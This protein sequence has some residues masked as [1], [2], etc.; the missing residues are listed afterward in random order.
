LFLLPQ[1]TVPPQLRSVTCAAVTAP[2]Q[3]C[4]LAEAE[5]NAKIY[6]GRSGFFEK[7]WG[8]PRSVPQES[9]PAYRSEKPCPPLRARNMWS[10]D[11]RAKAPYE[12]A[13]LSSR[14]PQFAC[15]WANLIGTYCSITNTRRRWCFIKPLAAL[16]IRIEEQDGT[17]RSSE[18]QAL[19]RGGDTGVLAEGRPGGNY[20]S[21]GEE[22]N[23]NGGL[24]GAKLRPAH[25]T[26][27]PF[28]NMAR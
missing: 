8:W 23:A 10:R 28:T 3:V 25:L 16:V 2:I 22:G 24:F 19:S 18:V 27:T 1:S 21:G 12:P 15:Q 11:R 14:Y 4:A 6:R 20:S 7:Q 5:P 9:F 13:P 26:K 17:P